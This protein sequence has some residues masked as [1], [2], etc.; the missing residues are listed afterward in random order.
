MTDWFGL[1]MTIYTNMFF[2]GFVVESRVDKDLNSYS[3]K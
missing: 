2:M 3:L 1:Y